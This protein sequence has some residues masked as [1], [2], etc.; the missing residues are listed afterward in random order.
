MK[1]VA[2]GT[3]PPLAA[4]AAETP[5]ISTGIASG[6]TRIAINRPPRRRLTVSA[7]PIAP[8]KVKAGVPARSVT[9]TPASALSVE[10]EH[11]SEERRGDDQRQ[12]GDRPMGET[13]D[14]NHEFE[15]HIGGQDEIERSVLLIRLEQPVEAEQRRQQRRDPQNCRTDAGE[16][17]EIGPDR[18]RHDGDE[19][20][21][22][23]ETHRRAAA[24]AAGDGDFAS[25]KGE[26]G[27][28]H[29]GCPRRSSRAPAS[30]SGA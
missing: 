3:V 16:Q 17:H 15:R 29:A 1:G 4:A 13:F 27:L 6:S 28:S 26:E 19:D 24:D 20:Q 9:V 7:A 21:E 25:E 23:D 14:R 22:E 5:K 2:N 10:R 30:P 8:R 18:E 11:Q 12:A